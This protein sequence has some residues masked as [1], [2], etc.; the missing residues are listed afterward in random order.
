ML[1]LKVESPTRHFLGLDTNLLYA[2]PTAYFCKPDMECALPYAF[3]GVTAAGAFDGLLLE[4]LDCLDMSTL[5]GV[6]GVFAATFEAF[7]RP[8]DC[9]L[10]Q[11]S[12]P[13]LDPIVLP[14]QP[15][16]QQQLPQLQHDMPAGAA[17]FGWGQQSSP[18]TTDS[19]DGISDHGSF[20]LEVPDLMATGGADHTT[21]I[22]RRCKT[23]TVEDFLAQLT[24]RERRMLDA[25]G[26]CIP[27]HGFALTKTEQREL[28]Q[29]LR[30]VRNKIS[31]QD[32]RV[33]KR[34]YVGDLEQR[35]EAV[36]VINIGLQHRVQD[37]E[38]QNRSLFQ[39]LQDLQKRLGLKSSGTTGTCLMLVGL[40]F[41]LCASPS[42]RGDAAPNTTT[43]PS[44]FHART[45]KTVRADAVL[46]MP[47]GSANHLGLKVEPRLLAPSWFTLWWQSVAPIWKAPLHDAEQLTP[48]FVPVPVPKAAADLAN[49]SVNPSREQN[50]LYTPHAPRTRQLHE[51]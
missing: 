16:Q 14:Q 10:P 23:S 6:D 18:A 28:R 47:P 27:N 37:L 8:Q 51:L 31:A 9:R 3:A 44:A 35:V 22:M 7:V 40:C 24:E 4:D 34:E 30:K 11:L 25:E 39:Q 13:T 17:A 48:T 26:A 2:Q 19:S 46:T 20:V 29:S 45:L 12:L 5:Y 49:S 50:A 1:T 15:Q 21:K 43:L 32:S 38:A 33:R 42:L 41:A 36:T